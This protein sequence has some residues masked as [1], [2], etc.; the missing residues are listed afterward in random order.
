[1]K[2]GLFNLPRLVRWVKQ[3]EVVGSGGPMGPLSIS[4]G[5]YH[6]PPLRQR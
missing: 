2:Q 1:M 3:R 6:Q 5:L 4:L